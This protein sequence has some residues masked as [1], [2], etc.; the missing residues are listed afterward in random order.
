MTRAG[1]GRRLV[2]I[3]CSDLVKALRRDPICWSVP[4][5]HAEACARAGGRRRYNAWRRFMRI[6]RLGKVSEAMCR[7]AWG[8]GIF[9]RVARI[10]GVHRSTVCRDWQAIHQYR[11]E[12][13][14][15]RARAEAREAYLESLSPEARARIKEDLAERKKREK[16]FRAMWRNLMRHCRELAAR[17]LAGREAPKS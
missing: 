6:Q 16:E 7:F 3:V 9:S 8:R 10:L 11:R 17:E 2:Y 12:Q 4:V 14:E 13:E 15:K 1:R 5:S